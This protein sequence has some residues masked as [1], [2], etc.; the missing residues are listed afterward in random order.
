MIR[1]NTSLAEVPVVIRFTC[2]CGRRYAVPERHA[3]RSTHCPA[4]GAAVTIPRVAVATLV[5]PREVR[6]GEAP[7]P[8][9]RQPEV[10]VVTNAPASGRKIRRPRRRRG[11]TPEANFRCPFCRCN[12]PPHAARKI[13]AGGWVLFVILLL[14]FFPL[15]PLALLMTDEVLSC[16]ACGVKFHG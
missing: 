13:S 15:C 10:A 1:I 9:R 7:P 5:E 4:C 3:G 6:F 14:F 12:E 11:G 2:R 16:S 8:P